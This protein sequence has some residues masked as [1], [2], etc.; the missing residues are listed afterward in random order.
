[1]ATS[2]WSATQSRASVQ[3]ALMAFTRTR[4]TDPTMTKKIGT[5]CVVVE[6]DGRDG[7][8]RYVGVFLSEETA[9]NHYEP[10]AGYEVE[11]EMVWLLGDDDPDEG[12]GD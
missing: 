11:F 12:Q 4:G 9:R 6:K 2:T 5:V 8:E 3:R 1:M 10:R 7:V